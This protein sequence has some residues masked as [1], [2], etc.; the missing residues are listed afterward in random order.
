VCVV[1]CCKRGEVF[2]DSI[3]EELS[4]DIPIGK[5][6]NSLQRGKIYLH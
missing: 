5:S 1:G 6:C 4:V 3:S 2:A